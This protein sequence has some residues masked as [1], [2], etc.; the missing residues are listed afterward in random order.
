MFAFQNCQDSSR[1]KDLANQ[2]GLEAEPIESEATEL[3]ANEF[4]EIDESLGQIGN[5]PTTEVLK[6][7]GDSDSCLPQDMNLPFDVFRQ[8]ALPLNDLVRSSAFPASG[9]MTGESNLDKFPLSKTSAKKYF[10]LWANRCQGGPKGDL[11]GHNQKGN[12]PSL[13]IGKV[14]HRFFFSSVV[15][16]NACTIAQ[17]LQLVGQ[18]DAARKVLTNNR[19]KMIRKGHSQ[20]ESL[21]SKK[22][23]FVDVCYLY[24]ENA[25]SP[26]LDGVVIDYEVSDGR[27]PE[28]TSA[29]LSR[30]IDVFRNHELKVGLWTNSLI[31]KTAER[32]GISAANGRHLLNMFNFVSVL[33]YEA[34]SVSSIPQ[35]LSDQEKVYGISKASERKKIL[36]TV[37]LGKSTGDQLRITR[38]EALKRG[39]KGIGVWNNFA[40]FTKCSSRGFR[41]VQCLVYGKGCD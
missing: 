21:M 18:E 19:V 20:P 35:I 27:S 10:F 36:L 13:R 7:S 33:V 14:D 40:D 32:N 9:F 8:A 38:A 23:R 30:V 31:V 28:Q 29:V 1:L 15:K 4:E 26:F 17:S 24:F 39:Y 41:Q 34:N 2:T 22:G 37:G 16:A 5:V 6:A 11:C 3:E 25:L 12:L